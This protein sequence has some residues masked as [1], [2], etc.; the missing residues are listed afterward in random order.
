MMDVYFS[1]LASSSQ[2][3]EC[4][5]TASIAPSTASAPSH[6]RINYALID[7]NKTRALEQLAN[8]KQR[9]AAKFRSNRFVKRQ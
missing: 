2:R 8:V 5:S 1:R 6:S 7:F 3:S 9:A 4:S